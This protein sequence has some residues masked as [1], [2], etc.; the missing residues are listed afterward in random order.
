MF[1]TLRLVR[2]AYRCT[3][4]YDTPGGAL[5]TKGHG[6]LVGAETAGPTSVA[7]ASAGVTI[8]VGAACLWVVAGEALT[9]SY[10][11]GS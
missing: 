1:A 9:A 6:V 5:R 8:R 7:R 2:S 4:L 10:F 3:L 11:C